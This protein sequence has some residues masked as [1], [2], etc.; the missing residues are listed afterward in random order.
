MTVSLILFVFN[1]VQG[2]RY[3]V[4]DELNFALGFY[5]IA[6]LFGIIAKSSHTRGKGHYHYHS[7]IE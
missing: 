3:H 5:T 7:H 2:I 1:L 6:I 4:E